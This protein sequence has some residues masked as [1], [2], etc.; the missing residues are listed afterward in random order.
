MK[1]MT[2]SEASKLGIERRRAAGK[3]V[4]RKPIG[5]VVR[6]AIAAALAEDPT[7]SNSKLSRLLGLHHATIK[8]YRTA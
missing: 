3:V 5:D 4:G 7:L 8:K 1:P 6:P 2:R